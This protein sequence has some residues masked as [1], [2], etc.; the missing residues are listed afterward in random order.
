MIP[1]TNLRAGTIFEDKG[2]IFKVLNYEHIKVGRGSASVR[3]KV[4]NLKSGSITDKSFI[5]NAK[6]G[7]ASV[8]KRDYQYLYKDSDSAYFMNPQ[9]FEQI[10]IPLKLLSEHIFLK[11]GENFSIEFL[12]GEPLTLNLP[13]KMEFTVSDTGPDLRGNSAT[14]I[15][16]DAVLENG[17]IVR[18]PLFI[19]IGDRVRVD[20]RTREYT[21]RA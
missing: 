9:T 1:V 14:N 13:P 8:E 11:D 3:V 17:L 16:K 19:K 10:T 21:E 18:V 12:N 15:Y 4:Q 5:S 7:K 20:T 2:E 6:V